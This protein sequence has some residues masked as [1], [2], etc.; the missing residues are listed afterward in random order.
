MEIV[1]LAED[2]EDFTGN[3]WKLEGTLFDAGTG[4]AWKRISE[5][6]TV[7]NVVLTHTHPD[8][9]GNLGK[10]VEEYSPTVYAFEPANVPVEAVG[11]EE[12]DTVKLSGLEFQVYHT[13]GHKDD[14]I[15][16]YSG[17]KKILFTGDL[18]FPEGGFGR[19][20]LAEGDRE[21]LVE[22]IRKIVDLDVSSFYPGH[23]PAV[24][25]NADSWIK[26]S[27]EEAEKREPKY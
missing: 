25:E 19:T 24:T 20:D 8:H 15:C 5:L 6:E 26:K 2:A 18:I 3:V 11:L 1:N 16:L 13:P 9:V 14:S 10:L 17:E 4:D 7:E 23:G 21:K 12:G 27:L 22:S